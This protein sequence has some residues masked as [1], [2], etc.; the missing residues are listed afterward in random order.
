MLRRVELKEREVAEGDS[1][2]SIRQTAI[3]HRLEPRAQA[4]SLPKQE[5]SSAVL[6]ECRST[7][8]LVAPSKNVEL[9]FVETL[10]QTTTPA[11]TPLSAWTTHRILIADSLRGWMDYMAYLEQRLKHQV[12]RRSRSRR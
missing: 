12:S 2:W 11:Q 9:Q 10:H 7:F 6:T 3:Y 4:I 1:P 5:Q 8:L